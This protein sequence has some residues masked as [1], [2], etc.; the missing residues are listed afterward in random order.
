MAEPA[1]H[2]CGCTLESQKLQK[3]GPGTG[4]WEL[5]QPDLMVLM[6]V[7]GLT[8]SITKWDYFHRWIFTNPF[9]IVSTTSDIGCIVV[10]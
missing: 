8:D 6:G 10:V 1:K 3:N 5:H 2:V 4:T 7:I 9:K